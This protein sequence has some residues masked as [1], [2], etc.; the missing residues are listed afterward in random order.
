M[1]RSPTYSE[2]G[3]WALSQIAI[4]CVAVFLSLIDPQT[5]LFTGPVVLL[6]GIL[7][8]L[9]SNGHRAVQALGAGN[10]IVVIAVTTI[11]VVAELGPAD[12]LA[13]ILLFGLPWLIASVVIAFKARRYTPSK[14]DR[15]PW[16]CAACGYP[17]VGVAGDACPECGT[18]FDAR[19]LRELMRE[20]VDGMGD[21]DTPRSS[22]PS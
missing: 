11:I 14:R 2:F 3:P 20:M 5:V 1:K 9:S 19:K 17:L 12:S 10:C 6:Y 22:S 21:D 15:F 16:N 13:T 8:L 4:I 7:Q 18:R